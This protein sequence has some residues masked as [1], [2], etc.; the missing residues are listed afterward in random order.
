MST[1]AQ[2]APRVSTKAEWLQARRSLLAKE[3]ELTRRRDALAE[4]R[5]ELPWVKVDENYIFES[6]EGPTALADL[7]DGRSQL[8]VYHFMFDPAWSQGCKSC[9]LVA[10]HYAPAVIH[11]AHRDTTLVTVSRA[12]LEKIS[13]FQQ[14]MGWSF[15]WVSSCHNSF[16][17]DFNVSFSES[18]QKSGLPIYNYD[19]QPFPISEAPGISVFFNDDQGDVYHT[20]S[21]YAR[22]LDILLGVYNLLDMTPKGRGEDDIPIMSW[23]R[24]HDRYDGRPFVDPWLEQSAPAATT[25][26]CCQQ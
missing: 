4:E 14:R 7:F 12:P 8:I 16:N 13:A 5:R 3:K 2:S 6:P 25:N 22:G 18:E 26:S 10:D 1:L 23:V 15:R 24:H 11:L 20:Y 19:S 9:S 21:T 17:Q